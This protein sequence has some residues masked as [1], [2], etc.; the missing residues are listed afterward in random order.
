M[1][2]LHTS[3]WHLGHT[4]KGQSRRE[5]FLKFFDWIIETIII[6]KVDILLIA[7]DIFDTSTPNAE[8]QNDYF[9]FLKRLL[10]TGC[11]SVIIAGNHDSPYLLDAPSEL[12]L[13]LKIHVIGTPDFIERELIEIHGNSGELEMLIAAVPFLREGDIRRFEIGESTE[14]R[15]QKSINGIKKHY[16]DICQKAELIRKNKPIPLVVMGHLFVAGGKTSEGVR[17]IHV[18][19]LGQTGLDLFPENIDY[20][21]FGHLH[22]QQNIGKKEMC[23][24]SGSPIPMSFDEAGQ[25]KS[26]T[27][28]EFNGR[29]PNIEILPIPKFVNVIRI[30]GGIEEIESAIKE[31]PNDM[32][33]F[34]EVAYNGSDILADLFNMVDTIVAN[35]ENS[36][37]IN[38]IRVFNSNVCQFQFNPEQNISLERIE[39]VELFRNFLKENKFNE[40]ETNELV[41][42]YCEVEQEVRLN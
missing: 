21:A 15:E 14:S 9:N 24:Y 32:K 3:D 8:T 6:R 2:L 1:L 22:I 4:W 11:L 37:L 34:V 13:R 23:R 26:V 31:L 29:E 30:E 18:G 42:I 12:L 39:P 33:S 20:F 25:I 16:A 28:V 10:D 17:E 41:K 35:Q 5:E 40:E 19:T 7:G 27:L 38:L 36:D